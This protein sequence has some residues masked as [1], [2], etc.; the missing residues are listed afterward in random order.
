M[1][2][3]TQDLAEN[4]LL[5]L[6]V[7][8]KIQLPLSNTQL[9]Q[10]ILENNFI[11]YFTLQQYITELTNSEFITCIEKDGKTRISISEKGIDVLDLFKN[12]L[13]PSKTDSIDEYLSSHLYNIK[14]E[15]TVSADYTMVKSNNYI[16][17]I[18]VTENDLVLMDLHINVPSIKHAEDLCKRWKDNSSQI[19][20]DIMK[21]LFNT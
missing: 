5:L 15:L 10:I 14:K 11:N 16:V 13:S 3:N 20:T 19:Y 18:N 6:Y 7:L 8:S 12:I 4:K 17:N 2:K 1:L 9:T 21:S